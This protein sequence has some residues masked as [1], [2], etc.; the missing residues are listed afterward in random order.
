MAGIKRPHPKVRVARLG[1]PA[2]KPRPARKGLKARAARRVH[3]P[4]V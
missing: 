4:K 1:K 2:R 3:K